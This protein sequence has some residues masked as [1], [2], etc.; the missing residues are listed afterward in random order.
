MKENFVCLI[1]FLGLIGFGIVKDIGVSEGM[2]G[3]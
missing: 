1:V 3:V 2:W